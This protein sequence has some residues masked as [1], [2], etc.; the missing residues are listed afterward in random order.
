MSKQVTRVDTLF[1]HQTG[2]D[3]LVVARRDGKRVLRGKL[4]LKE[5]NAGPRPLRFL[6]TR[7]GEDSPRD[8]SQFVELARSAARIRISQQTPKDGRDELKEMLDGYQLEALTVRTC[9]RCAVNGRYSPI[10]DDTAIKAEHEHICRDCAVQELEGELSF[11]GGLTQ[12]AQERLE[13]L[14]YETG[15]LT[16]ITNLLQGELD[17]DLTKFDTISATTEDVELVETSTLDLHP[18][19]KSMLTERFDTLLPVQSLAIDNGLLDGDDQLVVSATATGKTLVGELAGINRMLNDDGKMLFLVPLVALANQKHEDF[20]ERYGHL[21][22][23]TIRV[24]ASRINDDGNRFDPNA[25]VIVGTY[26]G[27][28]HALRTGKDL[29]D[30]GTVVIDEVHTLKE[31]ERGHRLDGMIARL[32][33]YCESRADRS[34]GYGGA[35]WIYLSATVGNPKWLAQ[36]LRANLVEYEDRPVPIERHVT[37]ADGQEKPRI[38]NRLVRQAFDSKSSKGYRGQTIIFTNSRRRCHE[39]ARKMDYNAAAYHAG[40]DYGQRKRVERQFA[41][42]DLAAV[43]TTAALA[44]GVDFPASQVIFDTLAMGIE[45]LSVQEFSQMLGRAGRP[46]YHDKG[47]V[48]LLVEPDASYHNTMEMTE[49]E[50]AFKLLKGEMEEVRTVYDQSSAVEET[51][52]NIV[53]AGTKAKALNNRM[54]G[55]LPTTH[56]VGKLLEWG[57]ID[58][59]DPTPLGL[60]V[61][62]QFLSP[63]EAFA[64]LD[65]I[66]KGSSPYEIVADL[67]L[68]EEGR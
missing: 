59:L 15:D 46:D 63:K 53:V 50:V 42:Q 68:D 27:I 29:G 8:P 39:I 38:E 11:A 22:K 24:G 5:T 48:Y 51:L 49:D 6:V 14:L 16:R 57:F 19:L 52:A 64:I 41:N 32:K 7:K 67:E 58:G 4:E 17:P 43:V 45:W 60:A 9:R 20:K 44:A 37:F 47:V 61:T 33:H 12:A 54:L 23:V 18:N 66:R 10:T 34:E 40:L 65:G 13:E 2:D 21:G 31:E 26:E 1:L 55:E 35:Q 62:R 36:N 56:A 3:Y 25:D 30:I 28:D